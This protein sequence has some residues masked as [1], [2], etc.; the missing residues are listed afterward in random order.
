MHGTRYQQERLKNPSYVTVRGLSRENQM[1]VVL[2]L[3]LE[4]DMKRTCHAIAFSKR[5]GSPVTDNPKAGPEGQEITLT[6]PEPS[7]P[8]TGT[9]YVYK[10]CQWPAIIAC[11]VYIGTLA[12]EGCT[13]VEA[14]EAC[15]KNE[16][17]PFARLQFTCLPIFVHKPN[18]SFVV[19]TIQ[20]DGA[21]HL[22]IPPT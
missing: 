12:M 15:S 22:E 19:S 3:P 16:C 18:D 2:Q 9:T 14:C 11:H 8:V 6:G 7:G 10:L 20:F 4:T 21:R 13:I 1:N 5:R 17:G